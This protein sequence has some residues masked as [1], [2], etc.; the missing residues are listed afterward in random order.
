MPGLEITLLVNIYK[1]L[2]FLPIFENAEQ[3]RNAT[4]A[5]KLQVPVTFRT[6]IN[7]PWLVPFKFEPLWFA[8]ALAP[9]LL[10]SILVVLDQQITA[11]ICNRKDNKLKKG[12]GYHLDL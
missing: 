10:C 9:A 5:E 11:V 4:P 12:L 2:M 8:Y 3:T 7:R 6:T 1:Y